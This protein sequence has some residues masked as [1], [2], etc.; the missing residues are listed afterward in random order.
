MEHQAISVIKLSVMT[1]AFPFA[2]GVNQFTTAPWP[3]DTDLDRYA[4]LGVTAI[5]LCEQKLDRDRWRAQ[6]ARAAD[7]GMAISAVQPLVRTF[8]AS[9]MQPKPDG[10]AA[11]T[12]CLRRSIERLAPFAKGAPFVINTGAP[13]G[14]DV[15]AMVDICTERLAELAPFAADH[16]VRLALEPLSATSMN[17]ETAIWTMGQ[18]RAIVEAVD[19]PAV[20][21]C[22]DLWNVWQD[23]DLDAEI[24]RAGSL[25]SVLQVGDWRMP[26]S[27]GDRLVPD[28]GA[29]PIGRLLRQ[30]AATG[31]RGAC[32]VELFS[33]DVPDSLYAADLGE[34][35]R[36]SRAGLERAWA[37]EG[38]R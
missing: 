24:A 23:P 12:D 17:V 38:D 32:A 16:G 35:I 27:R 26:R 10:V 4:A 11:R 34:V 2:F 29:I 20:G 3:F 25:T 28:D 5:E 19:H 21:L 18:A 8:G 7:C 15:Q 30:V 22:L 6:M 37:E 31:W 13:K 14:G 1:D 33:N 36:R 9:A